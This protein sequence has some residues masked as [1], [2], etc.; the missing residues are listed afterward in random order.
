MKLGQE[1][2]EEY[3]EF[4]KDS[5]SIEIPF[6]SV[7]FFESFGKKLGKA[8]TLSKLNGNFTLF[9]TKEVI[10]GFKYDFGPG[11]TREYLEQVFEIFSAMI[12]ME[13]YKQRDPA[14]IME[15]QFALAA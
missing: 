5:V 14:E 2:L 11:E 3:A 4:S 6:I 13:Y 9:A 10:V 12:M 7:K 15:I 8:A 1:F